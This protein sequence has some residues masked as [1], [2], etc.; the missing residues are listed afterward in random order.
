[1]AQAIANR[2]TV[3]REKVRYLADQFHSQSRLARLLNVDRSNVSRWLRDQDPDPE[4]R[5]RLETLEFVFSRLTHFLRAGTAEK[6]LLG[7]NAHLGNRR[8][9]DLIREGRIAEVIAAIEQFELGSY[10]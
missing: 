5:S 1:M 9:I 2:E 7:V 3:F 4:N 6:W 10:A 8:P